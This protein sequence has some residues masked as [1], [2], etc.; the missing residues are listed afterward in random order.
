MNQTIQE[1]IQMTRF[2]CRAAD[3][4][5][6]VIVAALCCS[7]ASAQTPATNPGSQSKIEPAKL[8]ENSRTELVDNPVQFRLVQLAMVETSLK[9]VDAALQKAGYQ[10][11]VSSGKADQYRSNNE[12]MDRKGGGPVAWDKFYGK[13]ASEFYVGESA[14]MKHRPPQFDYIYRANNQEA[15]KAEADVAALGGKIDKLLDRKRQ[16]EKEQVAL[17]TRITTAMVAER[18]IGERPMYG[19]HLKAEGVSDGDNV[20]AQRIAAIEALAK[21]IRLLDTTLDKVDDEVTKDQA[22][23]FLALKQNAETARKDLIRELA[24]VDA[25]DI[26]AKIDPLSDLSKRLTVVTNSAIETR[27][28]AQSADAVGDEQQKMSSRG[29]LQTAVVDLADKTAALDDGIMKLAVDWKIK[30]ATDKPLAQNKLIDIS[31]TAPGVNSQPAADRSASQAIAANPNSSNSA[32]QAG[33]EWSGTGPHGELTIKMF[34]R[35]RNGDD[36]KARINVGP[37]VYEVEGT[38]S[39]S[40]IS[41]IIEDVDRTKGKKGAKGNPRG[42]ESS[43]NINGNEINVTKNFNG[44]GAYTLRLKK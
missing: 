12:M 26:T 35:E 22:A 18:E 13:T 32:L 23:A 34:I 5:S 28:A 17:W 39:G 30:P 1:S 38:L 7:S 16:L 25:S 2:N 11:K 37:T 24:S 9:A 40:Q 33:T 14:Y 19:F 27:E 8:P 42:K 44:G 36:F 15:K 41:W 3:L 6:L 31:R 20:I 10:T 21:Y 4:L 29:L 43:G